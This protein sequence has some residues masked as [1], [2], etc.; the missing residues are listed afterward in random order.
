M[1]S[2]GLLSLHELG[3]LSRFAVALRRHAAVRDSAGLGHYPV[4]GSMLREAEAVMRVYEPTDHFERTLV[5]PEL[6]LSDWE[7]GTAR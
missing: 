7:A 5:I 3:T 6:R 1:L 4:D 2:R